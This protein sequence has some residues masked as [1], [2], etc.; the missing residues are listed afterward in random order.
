VWILFLLTIASIS[1]FPSADAQ[2][3][4]L[5]AHSNLS[6]LIGNLENVDVEIQNSKIYVVGDGIGVTFTRSLDHGKSFEE[7]QILS[8]AKS[9]HPIVKSLDNYIYVIWNQANQNLHSEVFFVRSTDFGKTFEDPINLSNTDAGIGDYMIIVS[10]EHVYVTWLDSVL[11]A[12]QLFLKASLDNGETFGNIVNI[13]NSK[14]YVSKYDVFTNQDTINVS[15]TENTG[16]KSDLYFKQSFDNGKIF[17]EKIKLSDS[18]QQSSSARIVGTAENI[19]L[20]WNEG[21]SLH[22]DLKF[23][24]SMNLGKTFETPIS[25]EGYSSSVN[26]PLIIANDDSVYLVGIGH[27]F[28]VIFSTSNNEGK[29]FQSYNL[30]DSISKGKRQT[31]ALDI[32]GNSIIVAW[33]DSTVA[34]S[35]EVIFTKS[36][37]GG[38]SFG[39]LLNLS[40]DAEDSVYPKFL[41]SDDILYILWNARDIQF[42]ISEDFGSTFTDP[43]TFQTKNKVSNTQLTPTELDSINITSTENEFKQLETKTDENQ[44][45]EIIKEKLPKPEFVDS[46]KDPQY[47]IDR[48]NNEPEYKAW[49]DEN[50]PD[51]TIHE[52]VGLPELPKEK[53]PTWIKN[54]AKWWSDGQIDDDTF[55]SGIQHLMVEKI[56]NIPTLSTQSSETAQE[57]VPT[58][59]K[60]NAKWWSEGLISEDDFVKGIEFLVSNGVIRIVDDKKSEEIVN[61]IGYNL[62]KIDFEKIKKDLENKAKQHSANVTINFLKSETE[63]DTTTYYYDIDWVYWDLE[64]IYDNKQCE[65][66][67]YWLDNYSVCKEYDEI[68]H[69]IDKIDE[70]LLE[71]TYTESGIKKIKIFL[72]YSEEEENIPSWVAY[73]HDSIIQVYSTTLYNDSKYLF[74]ITTPSVENPFIDTKQF[75]NMKI[76]VNTDERTHFQYINEFN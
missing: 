2:S 48:Y 61:Q 37:N 3:L 63:Q 76:S 34:P 46:S 55:V 20:I 27:S 50:Y 65:N 56:V 28:E 26:L 47:Y 67:L 69:K 17:G 62:H 52:A 30:V 45:T 19:Y 70:G 64:K 57:K 49:F 22:S 71:F 66:P 38:E 40:S 23:T 5:N 7:P 68:Y 41:T 60:N 14:E 1:F 59:I 21:D 12:T 11:G 15:Y 33:S 53:V 75:E 16:I 9:S 24:A 6:N 43:Q 13:S 73:I 10:G 8:S 39:E 51:Y 72:D 44:K 36:M 54:N 29:N 31:F 58:W 18:I 74:W 4:V 42:T 25:L 35:Y 32:I